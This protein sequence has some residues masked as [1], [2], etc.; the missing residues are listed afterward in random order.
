MK[1]RT[2][3]F[4]TKAFADWDDLERELEGYYLDRGSGSNHW[5]FRG[6]PNVSYGLLNSLER[7]VKG[8][9]YWA[10]KPAEA[11]RLII[12]E[13]KRRAHHYLQDVR[14]ETPE[15]EWLALMQHHGAPTRL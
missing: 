10:S 13:Y 1:P 14:R 15:D 7:E 12:A 11:E 9:P 2:A 4:R 5:L 8:N 3:W 6:V